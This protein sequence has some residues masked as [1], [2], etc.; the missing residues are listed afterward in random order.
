MNCANC[1]AELVPGGKFCRKCGAPASVGTNEPTLNADEIPTRELGAVAAAAPVSSSAVLE[2]LPQTE[3]ITTDL[4]N[5]PVVSVNVTSASLSLPKKS[6]WIRN[7]I[8]A[9]GAFIV[10]L[11]GF[12][13]YRHTTAGERLSSTQLAVDEVT[14]F[15]A[16]YKSKEPHAMARH[17]LAQRQ[18]SDD[19][20]TEVSKLLSSGALELQ[21]FKVVKADPVGTD[22]SVQVTGTVKVSG[23]SKQFTD[24]VMVHGDN[25][26]WR[27][28]PPTLDQ[29]SE[30]GSP[31]YLVG[32][33]LETILLSK[34]ETVAPQ[35]PSTHTKQQTGNAQNPPAAKSTTPTPASKDTKATD[36]AKPADIPP[37]PPPDPRRGAPGQDPGRNGAREFAPQDQ[38]KIR[39][40]SQEFQAMLPTFPLQIAVVP[41]PIYTEEAKRKHIE[42]N[43]V[44]EATFKADGT[45]ANPRILRG[46]GYGLD[47][48]ALEVVKHVRFSPARIEGH[49]VDVT[50]PFVVTFRLPS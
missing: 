4:L 7:S 14:S 43:I 35:T 49:P 1:N 6:H 38:T 22:I 48:Q 40:G 24:S 28:M 13:I 3:R 31:S 36:P 26:R 5:K 8:V 2:N 33:F 17:I 50:R 39:P 11:S 15:L 44:V 27:I 30:Q 34:L 16:D 9:L 10:L 37:P 47:E 45:V 46:L 42:G 20:I 32:S 29:V 23:N 25:G 18:I 21:D 12:L 41:K 19:A